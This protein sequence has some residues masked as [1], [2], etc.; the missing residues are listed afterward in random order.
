M[1]CVNIVSM[2]LNGSVMIENSTKVEELLVYGDFVKKWNVL[3]CV[4]VVIRYFEIL[5]STNL[6]VVEDDI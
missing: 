1:F 5:K 2:S 3:R 6:Y 4:Q